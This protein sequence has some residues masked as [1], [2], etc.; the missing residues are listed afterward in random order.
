MSETVESLADAPFAVGV[1]GQAK[2][3]PASSVPGGSAS[4]N[5]TGAMVLLIWLVSILLHAGGLVAALF[6]VFP[7]G[8]RTAPPPPV[9]E[10]ELVGNPEASPFFPAHAPEPSE[11]AQPV[12]PTDMHFEPQR[13]E[14][15]A[16]LE[17]SRKSDLPIIGIGAGG[18]D[19]SRYGLAVSGG[20]APDFFGL[21]SSAP[22]AR[23]IVYV[24]DRSGSMLAT[25]NYVRAELKRSISALDRSQKFH[26]I[27]FSAGDPVEMPPKRLVS[28]IA[29]RKAEFF[30]FLEGVYPGGRTDPAPAMSRAFADEPD[31]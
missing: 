2:A 9:V 1:A 15:L 28:A 14:R 12:D 24:V 18:G 19:F 8:P 5:L 30:E 25:F 16:D 11:A 20:N 6:L 31:V 26:V 29:A 3:S 7:F 4:V 23:R 21:G 10:V 17:V 13:A 22:G 27:F